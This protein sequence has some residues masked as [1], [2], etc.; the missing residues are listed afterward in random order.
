MR[1]ALWVVVVGSLFAA[2]PVVASQSDPSTERL[3]LALRDSTQSLMDI[4]RVPDPA[5]HRLGPLTVVPPGTPGELVRVS[6][7]IGDLTMRA[8]RAFSDM[9]RRRAERRA[10]EEVQRAIRSLDAQQR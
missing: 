10:S 7:P 8:A 3:R 1:V 9:Q 4:Y 6:V 5:P 2:S